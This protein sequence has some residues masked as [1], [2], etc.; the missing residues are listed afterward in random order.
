LDK[1]GKRFKTIKNDNRRYTQRETTIQKVDR[2][3]AIKTLKIQNK[4]KQI[5]QTDKELENVN[6]GD[7]I[8]ECQF[9][10]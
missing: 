1:H 2:D 6:L 8:A 7:F 10:S 5:H 3:R 4:V 9:F